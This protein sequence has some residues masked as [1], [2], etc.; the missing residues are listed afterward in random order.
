[1]PFALRADD[2]RDASLRTRLVEDRAR[3]VVVEADHGEA[4]HPAGAP[5]A[6]RDVGD[7]GVRQVLQR[8]GGRAD[9][10]GR[11]TGRPAAR[12][13]RGP[14]RR[15]PRPSAPRPPGS[16]GSVIPSRTTTSASGA[17]GRVARSR[18][19]ICAAARAAAHR[20]R[21][22]AAMIGGQAIQ[23]PP[24]RRADGHLGRAGRLSDRPEPL[25]V[26]CA[27]RDEHLPDLP[28]AQRLDDGATAGDEL[29]AHPTTASARHPMPSPVRP[30]PSGRVAFTETRSTGRPEIAASRSRISTPSGR[31]RRTVAHD[32]DVHRTP[33]RGRRRRGAA[34]F[35]R[36]ARPRR[37]PRSP[38]SVSGKCSPMSPSATAPSSASA[39]A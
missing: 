6:R 31:D 11:D 16:A 25:R 4:R 36:G 18:S 20:P 24:I 13:S 7:D 12:G 8:A 17:N 23:L 19:P 5:S 14:R 22:D 32:G 1:M 15:P 28:R 38:E 33:A 10:R 2:H 3:S 27:D 29:V 30:S 39:I 37:S 21:D 9:G 35:G 34:G 26:T